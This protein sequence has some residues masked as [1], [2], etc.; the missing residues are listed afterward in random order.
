MTWR[1]WG[2]D[3]QQP[4]GKQAHNEYKSKKMQ[5]WYIIKSI[6]AHN[7]ATTNEHLIGNYQR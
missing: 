4:V 5:E 7:I 3:R 2:T 1:L 6:Q